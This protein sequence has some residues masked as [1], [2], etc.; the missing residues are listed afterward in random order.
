LFMNSFLSLYSEHYQIMLPL[1]VRGFAM[2]MVFSPL[3]TLAL[4]EIPRHKIAQASGL[5]NVLRQLGG[6]FGVALMGALLTRRVIYHT[7]TYGQM[8]DSYSPAFR[9]VVSQLTY[10]SRYAIGGTDAISA[11]RAKSLIAAHIVQQSFV[12]AIN[13]DFL[14]AAGITLLSVIPIFLLRVHKKKSPGPSAAPME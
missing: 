8:I 11:M 4:S 5:F 12:R 14:V 13:D 2:G 10:F 9:K 6:S 7:A 3:S 1:Y